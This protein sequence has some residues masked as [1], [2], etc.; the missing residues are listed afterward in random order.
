MSARLTRAD[1]PT[2]PDGAA[3]A[4]FAAVLAAGAFRETAGC[5]EIWAFFLATGF[6]GTSESR[7]ASTSGE[8]AKTHKPKKTNHGNHW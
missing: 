5:H 7:G 1:K 4:D 6:L 3:E 8:P 2:W